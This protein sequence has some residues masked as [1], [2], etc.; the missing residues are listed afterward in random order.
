MIRSLN[1]VEKYCCLVS[2]QGDPI[3]AMASWGGGG[4]GG[5]GGVLHMVSQATTDC[6]SCYLSDRSGW[7]T[8]KLSS[9]GIFDII[10]MF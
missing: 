2:I 7:Q 1:P 4:G 8:V 9:A 10:S 3:V 5:G 6:K